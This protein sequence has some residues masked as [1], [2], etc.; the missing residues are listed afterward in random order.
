MQI[1]KEKKKERTRGLIVS[2]SY[3]NPGYYVYMK[4]KFTCD[5]QDGL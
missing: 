3:R 2:Q 4:N 5:Q 1:V